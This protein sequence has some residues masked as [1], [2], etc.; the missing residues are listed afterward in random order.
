MKVSFIH[1]NLHPGNELSDPMDRTLGWLQSWSGHGG[2]KKSLCP[3]SKSNSGCPTR[4]QVTAVIDLPWVHY[5]WDLRRDAFG[6]LI[7]GCSRKRIGNLYTGINFVLEK[8]L[9]YRLFIFCHKLK[10]RF[11]YRYGICNTSWVQK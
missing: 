11:I 6:L 9:T 2:K 1:W 5:K 8:I 7:L 3:C 4:S 10:S